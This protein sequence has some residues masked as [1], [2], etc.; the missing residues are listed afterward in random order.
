MTKGLV[1]SFSLH[2][3]VLIL[4]LYGAEL[5][6][7]NKNF[8]IYEI[9]LDIV[10]IS[11]ITVQKIDKNPLPKSRPK[12]SNFF[13]PPT[14]KS[15][16]KPPEYNLKQEN[17]KN[18]IK[19]EKEQVIT[20][21]DKKKRME[22]ILKSIEKIKSENQIKQ[23][24]DKK[25]KKEEDLKENLEEKILGDKLTLSEEDAIK[26]QFYRCWIVPAGAK[27][28]KDLVVSIKIFLN[29]EGEVISSKLINASNKD[30]F[31]RAASESAIRAVNH[32]EC[33]KLK[34]PKKKYEIWN[35]II[36]DFDP[37]QNF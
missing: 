9:P 7:Q 30:P 29:Q 33:K 19:S 21:K 23:D 15:K 3:G 28:L 32:P 26:R 36:L 20:K 17:K 34:V 12:T 16:P 22:S 25:D 8:E 1:K 13:S 24:D 5:F 4:F 31:F 37:S 11:E 2:L 35:E 10:D 6:K 27:N 14:P 18:E